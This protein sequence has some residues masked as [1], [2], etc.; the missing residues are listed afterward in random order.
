MPR[1]WLHSTDAQRLF[2]PNKC[3]NRP[4]E[5]SAKSRCPVMRRA[6]RS[7]LIEEAAGGNHTAIAL[8]EYP[9]FPTIV[10]D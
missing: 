1:A 2:V 7:F 3:A 8:Y 9:K 6:F 10:Q 5:I 4:C